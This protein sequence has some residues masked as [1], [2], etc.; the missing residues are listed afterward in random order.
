M[1]EARKEKHLSWT[2][3]IAKYSCQDLV[4]FNLV[5]YDWLHFIHQMLQFHCPFS[6]FNELSK[7]PLHMVSAL[8]Q[9]VG[10]AF[11]YGV[12]S[13]HGC[14]CRSHFDEFQIVRRWSSL[15]WVCWSG[16]FVNAFIGY[17]AEL[18]IDEALLLVWSSS[19]RKLN[20]LGIWNGVWTPKEKKLDS[21]RWE[22]RE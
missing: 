8:P 15:F 21:P 6:L 12:W 1:E 22:K 5:I 16:E 4:P 20:F 11:S 3:Y 19:Y 9:C 13:R 2:Q 18:L 7:T 10:H 17:L 14:C